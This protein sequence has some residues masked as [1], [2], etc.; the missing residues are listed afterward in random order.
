MTTAWKKISETILKHSF[1]KQFNINTPEGTKANNTMW[2]NT[3]H[4]E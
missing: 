2:E 3:G 1:K 4:D